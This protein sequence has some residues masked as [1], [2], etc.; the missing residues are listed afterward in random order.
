VISDTESEK[1]QKLMQTGMMQEQS[2]TQVTVIPMNIP[3]SEKLKALKNIKM[4]TLRNKRKLALCNKKK[5]SLSKEKEKMDEELPSDNDHEQ[6]SP[7]L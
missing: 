6:Q 2:V 5:L 3:R 4:L 7:D 1:I